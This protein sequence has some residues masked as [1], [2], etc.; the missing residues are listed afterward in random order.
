MRQNKNRIMKKRTTVLFC[1]WDMCH[2]SDMS[3]ICSGKRAG[4]TV[5]IIEK[6]QDNI[7]E[8]GG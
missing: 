7:K 5:C 1:I 8:N 3:M 4:T 2:N 6:T